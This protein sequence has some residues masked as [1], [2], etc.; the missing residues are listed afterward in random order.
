M[1]LGTDDASKLHAPWSIFRPIHTE[2]AIFGTIACSSRVMLQ[3]TR[4]QRGLA[5][6]A[7]KSHLT[8]LSKNC[9]ASLDF[10]FGLMLFYRC[11]L[12]ST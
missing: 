9:F 10:G 3:L 5:N 12:C 1:Q 8:H 7:S 11:L 6:E 4:R 2:C